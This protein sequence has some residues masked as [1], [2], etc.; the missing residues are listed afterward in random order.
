M[1]DKPALGGEDDPSVLQDTKAWFSDAFQPA[2]NRYMTI[3]T[4]R[5]K[6]VLRRFFGFLQEEHP[7]DF[8]LHD[9]LAGRATH[10]AKAMLDGNSLGEALGATSAAECRYLIDVVDRLEGELPGHFPRARTVPLK[11]ALEDCT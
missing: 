6:A 5:E 1:A 11:A 4:Q 3:L 2:D 9:G 10:A 8:G 7:D